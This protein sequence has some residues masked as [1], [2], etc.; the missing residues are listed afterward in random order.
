[1]ANQPIDD[2]LAESEELLEKLNQDLAVLGDEEQTGQ[3]NPDLLNGIFRDAHSIKG[4]AGM[5]GFE[6][7]A[8]LAHHLENLLDHL[9]LGKVVL[10]ADLIDCLFDVLEG[11]AG[12]VRGKTENPDFSQDISAYLTRIDKLLNAPAEESAHPFAKLNIDSSLLDVLTEYE[13]HRLQENLKQGKCLYL[14]NVA[15]S[16]TSFDTELA[17]LTEK[18]KARGEVISTLPGSDNDNPE[19]LAFRILCGT[20]LD[21]E[22]LG[23]QLALD[24]LEISVVADFAEPTAK[25]AAETGASAQNLEQVVDVSP[26]TPA[27]PAVMPTEPAGEIVPE[28]AVISVATVKK[29]ETARSF[30]STVRVDIGKLDNLMNIVGELAL[31]KASIAQLCSEMQSKGVTAARDL[32]K[33]VHVL[34]RR[35]NDLQTGVMDVRMVPVRQLFDK[36]NRIVRRMALDLGKKVKLEIRGGDTELDKLIVE[37]LADPLMHIIRNALDHGIE[38]LDQRLALG[39]PETGTVSLVAAQ[40]G[41]HVVIEIHDDGHGIDPQLLRSKGIA[42]GLISAEAKLSRHELFDLLFHSGFSTRDE[43]S[44]FS[45]RGVG[46]D[47]VKS[48]ISAMSGMIE[49]NSELGKGTV[50]SLTLPIT[51]AIIKAPV[52]QVKGT[53]YAIPLNSVMETVLLEPGM[54][55]TIEGRE[56]ME[57]RQQTLSLLRIDKLFGFTGERL[58]TPQFVVVAGFADK[59]VGIVVDE[60]HGQQD[61]VIKSLGKALSF[62]KGIAGAADLGNQKTIL[63][64][65]VSGLIGVTLQRESLGV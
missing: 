47:V 59:C 64:L 29:E 41:N 37:D 48:N 16:L 36:M 19:R 20:T 22:Q 65:D 3:I 4:L 18:I 32:E 30:T 17:A 5:F 61:V 15:F 38:T 6:D 34:E 33:A 51:L 52:V 31:A 62:V 39:K 60:L 14:V 50:M 53:D 24:D 54:V 56:V 55:E 49:V 11:L 35:L 27:Q 45:G 1:M 21:V 40:K 43:V 9:R 58:A 63:V 44:E 57:L 28:P 25:K 42:K 12:L 26:M 13:E 7:I 23:E 46:M 8:D 10:D 2:F